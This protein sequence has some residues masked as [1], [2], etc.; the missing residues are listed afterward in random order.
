MA[1]I[2]I[3]KL[4]RGYRGY[5]H[6]GALGVVNLVRSE[7]EPVRSGDGGPLK[8]LMKCPVTDAVNACVVGKRA[9]PDMWSDSSANLPAVSTG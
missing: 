9:F 5:A 4:I 7:Q 3:Q 8:Q 6:H 1:V 2:A